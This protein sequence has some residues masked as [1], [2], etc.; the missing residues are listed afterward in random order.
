MPGLLPPRC[1]D[2]SCCPLNEGAMAHPP[3]GRL[4]TD[5][6]AYWAQIDAVCATPDDGPLAEAL[7]TT[8]SRVVELCR[9]LQIRNREIDFLHDVG[10]FLQ[11]SLGRDEIIVM[12]LTAVTAGKGYGLNRAILFLVNE[13]T[14]RLEGYLAVGPRTVEEAGRIW[15]EVVEHDDSL[16]ALAR[17]FL[18]EKFAV[19]QERFRDLLDRLSVDAYRRDHL[20]ITTLESRQSAHVIE[21]WQTPG[22]D[23]EQIALLGGGEFVLVPLVSGEHRIG[24]LL[25]DNIVT[26]R[27]IGDDDIHR[28][29]TFALPVAY[30]IERASLYE[31]L[32]AELDRVT[33]AHH[34]LSEQQ[35]LIVR[36]EKSA[37]VGEISA[38]IAHRI[39]NPL[40]IIG[41]YSRRLLR[42]CVPDSAQFEAL[43]AI[44]RETESISAS[45][46]SLIEYAAADHPA[47]D[48][49]DLASTLAGALELRRAEIE[50]AGVT[51][52]LVLPESG[53]EAVF[54][55]R[56][57]NYCLNILIS[58][59]LAT[60]PA[61]GLLGASCQ[62]ADGRV[63]AEIAG[64]GEPP[65]PTGVED[66]E[67]KICTRMLAEQDGSL[68]VGRAPGGGM[69]W[70]LEL[71]A[72]KEL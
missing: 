27:P 37:L 68:E 48:V 10:I 41:G 49:W 34:R 9:R 23:H 38:E 12:A 25:A 19:E 32:R 67:M 46:D 70:I 24:L 1:P 3:G 64:S 11:G 14:A 13:E 44:V 51:L 26:N 60:M 69:L 18:A 40:S 21:P 15:N 20:F 47:R 59:A 61:G 58:R 16:V 22:L 50:G 53:A 43:S 36:M 55:L 33:I 35:Q 4:T 56:K 17:R 62:Q 7:L 30:A 57:T 6:S 72:Q 8:R 71:P 45:I 66:I 39:R 54:D 28:L 5:C 52:R 31:R 65:A 29:E 42:E 2:P 63:R